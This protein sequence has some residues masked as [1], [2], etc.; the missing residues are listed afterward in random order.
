MME[1]NLKEKSG[2]FSESSSLK[3]KMSNR[4]NNGKVTYL[5]KDGCEIKFNSRGE[6]IEYLSKLLSRDYKSIKAQVRLVLKGKCKTIGGYKI[7]E[8]IVFN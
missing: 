7:Y 4:K 1:T 8:N 5:E 6:L 3:S 2:I